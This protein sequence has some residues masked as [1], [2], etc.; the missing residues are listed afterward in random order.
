MFSKLIQFASSA[1]QIVMKRAEQEDHTDMH[2]GDVMLDYIM[3]SV[4][5]FVNSEQFQYI[6]HDQREDVREMA[7]F[8][9]KAQNYWLVR[10]P[11]YESY[12]D[13]LLSYSLESKTYTDAMLWATD[14]LEEID[15]WYMT[16]VLK[17]RIFIWN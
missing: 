5:D 1:A 6:L 9:C 11:K 10:R 2:V 7:E 14:V 17:H 15:M 3:D 13:N 4:C 12:I 16:E 8:M